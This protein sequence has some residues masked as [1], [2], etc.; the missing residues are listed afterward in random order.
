MGYLSLEDLL[1]T[2]VAPGRCLTKSVF[3]SLSY[4]LLILV[5][6]FVKFKLL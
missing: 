6:N 4:L 3:L 2:E 1:H 5:T